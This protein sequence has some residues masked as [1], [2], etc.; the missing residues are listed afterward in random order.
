MS[1]CVQPGCESTGTRL[2]LGSDTNQQ[3][4]DRER[5]VRLEVGKGRK[6]DQSFPGVGYPERL[7]G[8][9]PP[10]PQDSGQDLYRPKGRPTGLLRQTS[11]SPLFFCLNLKDPSDHFPDFR[12][13][14]SP[15]GDG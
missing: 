15:K 3:H 8:V 2:V 10:K 12:W 11:I 9:I 4:A 13:V 5:D 7:Q 1:V 14:I 6:K